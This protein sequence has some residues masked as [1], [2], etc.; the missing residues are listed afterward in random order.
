MVAAMEGHDF[1][2]F[3]EAAC[4]RKRHHIGFGAGVAEADE[5]EIETLGNGLGEGDFAV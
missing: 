5:I 1:L 2:T 3:C 4:G